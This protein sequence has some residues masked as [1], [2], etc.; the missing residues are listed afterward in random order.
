MD[1]ELEVRDSGRNPLHQRRRGRGFSL[2]EAHTNAALS[3]PRHVGYCKN[4]HRPD[5]GGRRPHQV[6]SALSLLT[7]TIANE[8]KKKKRLTTISCI[9]VGF[10]R[11]P[12][13]VVVLLGEPDLPLFVLFL[14]LLVPSCLSTAEH[15]SMLDHSWRKERENWVRCLVLSLQEI[16]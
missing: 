7:V 10:P 1:G 15:S 13:R 3:I 12:L 5:T 2:G 8:K 9:I 6:H 11:L 14:S 16:R 4:F